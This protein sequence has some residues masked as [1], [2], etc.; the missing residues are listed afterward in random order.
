MEIRFY[1]PDM[2]FIG[3]MENQT[4]LVWTRKFY[5]PGKA[6]LFAPLTEENLNLTQLGN[7]IWMR[8]CNEAAVIEDRIIEE[9]ATRSQI[10]VSGRFISSYMDRRL[11][12]PKV[13]FSGYVEVAMRSLL[14]GAEAIPRVEL[15]T[16][17]NFT[18]PVSFQAT[19]KNLLAYQTKLSRCSNIG[20]RFRP[21][22]NAKKIY[23]ETY[24]GT[25]RSKSQGVS[26]RVVF[27][28]SYDNLNEMSYREN[29]QNYKN[30][31]YIGGTGQN[32]QRI[33]VSYGN[34]TGLNRRELFV[35][36]RDITWEEG[37]TE[38]QYT[39]KLIQRGHEKNTAYEKINTI[40]C[41]TNVNANFVYKQ[42]YD[43]GD[44]VTVQKKGWGIAVDLRVVELEEIYERGVMMVSPVFGSVL[45]ETIDWGDN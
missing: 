33:Y 2:D 26:H 14:S 25:D 24:K 38:A 5:E 10:E 41:I 45:P 4:S 16:L 11:I 30:V 3:V 40:N 8:G 28:E 36:A 18:D 13:T 37:M 20:Y 32:D 23:F 15:G 19:Y 1:D 7:L 6:S 29:D 39:E 22:F 12:R 42:D 31:V 9:N 34:A 35:D 17:N 43:L 21:D 44:I 27:S